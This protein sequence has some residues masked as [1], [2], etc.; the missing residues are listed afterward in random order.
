M[1][2]IGLVVEDSRAGLLVHQ[3]SFL[4]GFFFSGFMKELVRQ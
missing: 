3:N 2:I 1:D 4:P